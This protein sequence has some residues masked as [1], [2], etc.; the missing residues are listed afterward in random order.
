[1]LRTV[2]RIPP[3]ST[4]TLRP[5]KPYRRRRAGLRT[6]PFSAPGVFHGD[7]P[8][9]GSSVLV[10]LGA[11]HHGRLRH[12]QLVDVEYIEQFDEVLPLSALKSD[13]RLD[14]MMVIKRGM[15]LS[16][17]PVTKTHFKRVLK[18]TG[19]ATKVR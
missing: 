13:A 16:V 19:A 7:C 5:G 17:Q 6:L 1:M 4:I 11:S 3:L 14:G 12:W 18:L 2:E 9:V 15:R 10:G 8:V